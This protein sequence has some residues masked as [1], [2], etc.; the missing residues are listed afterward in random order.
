MFGRKRKDRRNTVGNN[1]FY[2]FFSK[3]PEPFHIYRTRYKRKNRRITLGTV[4]GGF[5]Y[6]FKKIIFCCLFTHRKRNWN[7]QKFGRKR[8]YRRNSSV[9]I[10]QPLK[11]GEGHKASAFTYQ[12][13]IPHIYQ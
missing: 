6:F 12:M 10:L 8:K 4:F 11:W 1:L 7:L 13:F 2:S 3:L 5:I 9:F